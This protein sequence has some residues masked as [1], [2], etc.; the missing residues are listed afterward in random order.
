[1][2]TAGAAATTPHVTAGDDVG[3][4]G[5]TGVFHLILIKPTHYDDDG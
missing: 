2:T 3:I 5:A 1:M 4:A